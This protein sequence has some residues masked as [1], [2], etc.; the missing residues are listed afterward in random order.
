MFV[1]RA[2]SES[3]VSLPTVPRDRAGFY[4]P[5]PTPGDAER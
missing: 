2:I 1:V 5:D 4:V 3:D